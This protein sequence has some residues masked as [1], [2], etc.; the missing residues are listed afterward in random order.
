MIRCH[1]CVISPCSLA[2]W[3]AP[4][5]VSIFSLMEIRNTHLD[6]DVPAVDNLYNAHD[7]VKDQTQFLTVVYKRG[8][9]LTNA[10]RWP[11]TL[12]CVHTR[13]RPYLK[14]WSLS[15]PWSAGCCCYTWRRRPLA[16]ALCRWSP[17]PGHPPGSPIGH[18]TGGRVVREKI[19]WLGA[20]MIS[21]C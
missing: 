1:S 18:H 12:K 17:G 20:V 9:L 7:V 10:L 13:V 3:P 21:A 6:L 14:W 2:E 8:T 15:C 16:W 11:L 5:T 4:F 19:Y